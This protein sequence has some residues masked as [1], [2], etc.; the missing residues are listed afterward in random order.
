MA[1][2][3]FVWRLLELERRPGATVESGGYDE[4]DDRYIYH[5]LNFGDRISEPCEYCKTPLL[6]YNYHGIQY[7]CQLCG[8]CKG[9]GTWG[10]ADFTVHYT[11]RAILKSFDINSHELTF[12]ELATHLRDNFSDVYNLSPRRF[13]ELVS[14]IFRH[15]GYHV[16]LTQA[17]RD[18]GYDMVLLTNGERPI[19]V[20]AKRY[21]GTVGVGIVRQLAGVQLING[22][23]EAVLVTSGH[24]SPVAK[25]EAISDELV[26]QGYSIK[27]LDAE[28]ILRALDAYR[29]PVRL[30]DQISIRRNVLGLNKD[31]KT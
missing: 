23:T 14:D 28:A 3:L 24:F 29:N 16:E 15:Q 27:L 9:E 7:L 1:D 22:F 30:P 17:T 8:F 26:R 31:L 10:P 20:E 2:S 11:R 25:Q 13:E 21:K 5:V 6:Y 12:S 19:I 4:M 18:G